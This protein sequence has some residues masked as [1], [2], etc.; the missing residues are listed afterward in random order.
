LLPPRQRELDLT[1]VDPCKDL[2][3]D[4]QLRELVYDLGYER[5]PR[6][7]TSD[8]HDGPGCSFSSSR[9]RD[10]QTRDIGSLVGVSVT[11]GAE[12]W[13]TD[14]AR[15]PDKP[16]EIVDIEGFSALVL[17]HPKLPDNC[18]VVVDTAESQYL[19]VSSS[20][21]TGEGTSVEPYCAEAERVAGMAIQTLSASR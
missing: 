8:I 21:D 2:L 10:Q 13:L 9:P 15:K 11:E 18:M 6:P 5:S 1:G 17:P 12:A 16:P 14:P 4:K 7:S 3:T 19:E 20:P